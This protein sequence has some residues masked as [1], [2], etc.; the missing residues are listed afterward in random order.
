M[1]VVYI[2][3]SAIPS[4]SANSVHVMKM[5]EA[6]SQIG[7]D[8]TLVVPDVCDEAYRGQDPHA[9]YGVVPS[10]RIRRIR[11]VKRTP[12]GLLNYAFAVLALVRTALPP[13]ATIFTRSLLAAFFGIL[14]GRRVLLEMH[15]TPLA[16][17]RRVTDLFVRWRL[18]DRRGFLGL[19]VIS[20]PLKEHFVSLGWPAR[21]VAVVPDAVNYSVFERLTAPTWGKQRYT[22]GYVGSLCKGRGVE[23][24]YEL[25]A[26]DPENDY[27]VY[28]GEEEEVREW[29]GRSAGRRNIAFLGHVRNAEIADRLGEMDILLMPYQR[30]IAVSG[31]FGDT[32]KWASPMKM[33][34][35][36][37]SGRPVISSEIPVLKEV[38][39]HGETCLFV[40]PE[41]VED[42]LAA[43]RSLTSDGDLA[44]GMGARARGLVREKYTWEKR[45]QAIKEML[46]GAYAG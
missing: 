2:A 15:D 38:L 42:W 37:A 21:K 44:L 10:F 7:A 32:A 29:K 18:F 13:G 6:L 8:L 22:I 9:F 25:S 19:V 45:A 28:G 14:A 3:N 5:C 40:D 34:E 17:S 41:K 24:I 11:S 39:S 16:V 4:R 35:Y 26:R 46:D 12:R 36:M 23:V 20:K 1:K 27:R 33:F 30:K 31:N 43:V